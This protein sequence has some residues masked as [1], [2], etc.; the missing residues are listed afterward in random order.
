[1]SC[2]ESAVKVHRVAE[3][4]DQRWQAPSQ[5]VSEFARPEA[6]LPSQVTRMQLD[7]KAV[8]LAGRQILNNGAEP[9]RR[10]RRQFVVHPTSQPRIRTSCIPISVAGADEAASRT[11][12]RACGFGGGQGRGRTA[13]LPLF[14]RWRRGC[15]SLRTP[16]VSGI[17]VRVVRSDAGPCHP[18]AV[19][20]A[21]RF[22]SDHSCP[23]PLVVAP[24]FGQGSTGQGS[25]LFDRVA[26]RMR[27]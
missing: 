27:P 26:T 8:L 10:R 2:Q 12:G 13:D 14:R 20:N 21:V 7:R 11:R 25:N 3:V 6:P 18:V 1:M 15:E 22:L 5:R 23:V 17:L 24:G 16:W 9:G 4:T 19:R